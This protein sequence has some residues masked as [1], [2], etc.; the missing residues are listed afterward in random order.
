MESL[1]NILRRINYQLEDGKWSFETKGM[2]IDD[3][4]LDIIEVDKDR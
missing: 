3:D 4:L 2:I 1:I